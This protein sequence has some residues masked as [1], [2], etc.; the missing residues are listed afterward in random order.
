MRDKIEIIAAFDAAKVIVNG[1][2][3]TNGVTGVSIE[4]EARKAIRATI[5]TI[6]NKQPLREVSTTYLAPELHIRAN[7]PSA[8]AKLDAAE[9]A[10]QRAQDSI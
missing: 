2:E 3:V 10:D 9:L 4:F 8:Q 7:T 1:E 5:R 6:A